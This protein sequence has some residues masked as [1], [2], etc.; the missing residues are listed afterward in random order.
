MLSAAPEKA[1]F[2]RWFGQ[3]K[4]VDAQGRPLRMYH[5]TTANFSTFMHAFGQPR[6]RGGFWFSANPEMAAVWAQDSRK[7]TAPGDYDSMTAGG[8][9]MPVY[10]RIERPLEGWSYALA[11]GDIVRA[12]SEDT[13]HDGFIV[14]NHDT[15]QVYIAVVRDARQVKSAIGNRGTFDSNSPNILE[16]FSGDLR[17]ANWLADHHAEQRQLRCANH[18]DWKSSDGLSTGVP[19]DR[20]GPLFARIGRQL[21]YRGEAQVTIYRIVP[22]GISTIRPGDWVALTRAYASTMPRGRGQRIL[23]QTVSAGD[24]VWAGTDE[25]EWWYCP[26]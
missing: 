10:L 3:S 23:A 11:G 21:P 17:G 2:R 8:N 19:L 1:A 7:A 15:R 20:A 6:G 24:V 4:V 22:V 26:R 14:R 12:L 13:I 25:N 16:G 5:G 18:A 9:L